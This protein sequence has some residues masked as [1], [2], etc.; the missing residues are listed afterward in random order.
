MINIIVVD[1]Q[2]DRFKLL[3]IDAL[4]GSLLFSPPGSFVVSLP[5]AVLK[6]RFQ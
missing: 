3:N 6:R 4:Q 5:G 1:L 2:V